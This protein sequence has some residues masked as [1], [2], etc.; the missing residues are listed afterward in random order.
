MTQ[1]VSGDCV[2][3]AEQHDHLDDGAGVGGGGSHKCLYGGLGCSWGVQL[4]V[5][6]HGFPWHRSPGTGE[7]GG[8]HGF[9]AALVG[10]W[11]VLMGE[12]A[13]TCQHVL[14]HDEACPVVQGGL[15]LVAA[16]SVAGGT[17]CL[18]PQR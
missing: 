2:V 9:E 11:G 1:S 17:P 7:G 15:H 6:A 12:A 8:A 5:V 18:V 3:A 14:C 13:H 4:L 10:G 16:A